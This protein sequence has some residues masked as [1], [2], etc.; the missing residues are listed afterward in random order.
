MREEEQRWEKGVLG[1][2][3]PQQL[4]DTLLYVFCIPFALRGGNEHSR[5]RAVNSQIIKGVDNETGLQYSEY[6]QDVSKTNAGGIKDR[7]LKKKETIFV[8]HFAKLK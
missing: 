3:Q 6:Q 5:L 8:A 2:S 4:L 1:D 7:K